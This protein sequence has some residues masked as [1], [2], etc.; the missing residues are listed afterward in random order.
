MGIPMMIVQLFRYISVIA[1]LQC[2]SS[3]KTRNMDCPRKMVEITCKPRTG[4]RVY[5]TGPNSTWDPRYEE[6]VNNT[7]GF[8]CFLCCSMPG[9]SLIHC[10]IVRELLTNEV[11]RN[12]SF[13]PQ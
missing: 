13:L 4:M 10:P 8:D 5:N 1:S 12:Q 6:T 2:I 7:D 9:T 3:C 11:L